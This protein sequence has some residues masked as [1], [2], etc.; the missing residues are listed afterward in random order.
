[1]QGHPYDYRVLVEY[2]N[3]EERGAAA[4]FTHEADQLSF[5]KIIEDVF[6]HLPESMPAGWEVNSH[7]LT[8]SRDT[9]IITV[10]LRRPVVN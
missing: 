2:V 7:S 8:I 3:P 5:T 1:M 10:L 9:I 6:K 4:H